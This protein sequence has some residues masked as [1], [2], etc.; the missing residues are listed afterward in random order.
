MEDVVDSLYLSIQE[1]ILVKNQYEKIMGLNYD[2]IRKNMMDFIDIV[3]TNH[4]ILKIFNVAINNAIL[5]E[6]ERGLK[7]EQEF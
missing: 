6:N 1:G 4:F 2:K 3:K 7:A 5:Y